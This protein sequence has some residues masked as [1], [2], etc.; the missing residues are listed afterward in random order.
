MTVPHARGAC[1][2]LAK[3]MQT[4]DGLLARLVT[5]GPIP[6]DAFIGLCA[7]AQEH[8]NGMMEI[9]SRGSLQ[10]RGLTPV[11]APLFASAVAGLD[12]ELC[13]RAPVLSGP[14][15]DDPAA[16]ID[17]DALASSLRRAIAAHELQLAPK[18]SV[19][20]DGGGWLHLDALT[21]DL[22]LQ[23]IESAEGTRLHVSI[24]GDAASA[25]PLDLVALDDAIDIAMRILALIA[26]SGP[27]ARAADLLQ[28]DGIGNFG[29]AVGN[30]M[31]RAAPLP[32]RQRAEPIGLHR[33]SVKGCAIGVA[34]A[35][36]QASAGDLM[37]FA[38]VAR[39]N[40]ATW[41]RPAPGRTLLLG[42]IDEMTGFGLATAAYG[43]GFVVDSCDPRRRIVACPGA[44]ACASGLIAA[45]PLAAELA[46]HLPLSGDDIAVH[47]SG[48]AKGCAYPGLAPLT[49]VGT[50]GGCGVVHNGT[51]RGR[52]QRYI[53]PAD[54]VAEV[55]PAPQ[56]RPTV[57][58]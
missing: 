20:I 46:E 25:T 38:G 32:R 12:I 47:V 37:A 43:F 6:L 55:L 39:A 2:R 22:R 10:V 48:C 36:G 14:L 33:L 19:V 5:A 53:D 50:A 42:P 4:G 44:P 30:R 40:G 24:A 13:E 31:A 49:V 35:F 56:R 54:F 27:A 11:S 28:S 8:G 21:A 9:S 26:T 57:D 51:A 29:K 15:P 17:A 1:P 3:P 18:V 23:A 7:A 52:P 16:L 41:A 34:L 58:A 45:R